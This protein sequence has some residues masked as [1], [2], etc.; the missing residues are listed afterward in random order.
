MTLNLP[1]R[2]G[3]TSYIL[4]DDLAA[5]AGF[6]ASHVDEMELVLFDLESGISNL[7]NVEMQKSLQTINANMGLVYTLHLPLDLS[8]RDG[9]RSRELA[10]KVLESARTLPVFG[11]VA[12]IEGWYWQENDSSCQDSE[13]F[14]LW[15]DEAR[16]LVRWLSDQV[17]EDWQV[18]I[19]NTEGFPAE[20]L[21][22]LTTGLP[23]HL[24]IDIGHLLKEK[25]LDP[26]GYVRNHLAESRII[27]LHG[28]DANGTDHQSVA[29][30]SETFLDQL[31]TMLIEV[32]YDG[33]LTME[34]FGFDDFKSSL[35]TIKNSLT[36]IGVPW[37]E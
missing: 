15:V 22:N 11:V 17:S 5:N 19:E 29:L 35:Q 13:L 16:Q 21:V 3:T 18:C 14:A 2:I 7:P 28:L 23:V 6:I 31:L 8:L 4:E 36:R 34:V 10:K 12:H 9:G 32:K 25:Y 24:C 30:L 1:F 20:K 26:L 33:V 37:V 27:H